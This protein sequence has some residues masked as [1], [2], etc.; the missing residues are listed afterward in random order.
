MQPDLD[1]LRAISF[2]A[3][4]RQQHY[5]GVAA[6][7]RAYGWRPVPAV[8][9]PDTGAVAFQNDDRLVAASFVWIARTGAFALA[10]LTVVDKDLPPKQKLRAI[11]GVLELVLREARREIGPNGVVVAY[12]ANATMQRLY[13]R[14]GFTPGER[15]TT[16][17]FRPFGAVDC[18]FMTEDNHDAA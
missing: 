17:F 6:L 16:S 1:T 8:C 4:V 13:E 15:N 12:S 10:S 3:F 9:L 14:H 2:G 5:D 7:Y 18:D 11:N